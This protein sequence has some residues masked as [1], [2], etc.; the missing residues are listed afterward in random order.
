MAATLQR[1]VEK[2]NIPLQASLNDYFDSDIF[3]GKQ[4]LEVE[5]FETL[6]NFLEILIPQDDR[7]L[8]GAFFTPSYVVILLLTKFSRRKMKQIL[9][10]VAVAVLF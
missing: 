2:H 4:I 3:I 6:E 9:T 5:N 7:K 10:Q 1:F 8:N